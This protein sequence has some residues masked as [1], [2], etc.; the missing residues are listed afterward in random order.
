MKPSKKRIK[1]I[2]QTLKTLY[3]NVKTQLTH[4]NAFELLIATI[5]SAQCTDKQVNAVTPALFERFSTPAALATAPIREIEALIH[6]TGFYHN[7]ARN[8]KKCCRMLMDEFLGEVPS[9]LEALI[10]LPGVGRKTANVVLGAAFNTPAM[11]V[12]THV[13][14]IAS[15]LNLTRHTD[16]V[17]I[18]FDLMEIIPRTE[19]N[20]FSLYLIYFG[21]AYCMA[22][23]PRCPDCPLDAVCAY[24]NKTH[25]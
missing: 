12:D 24:D 25:F 6:S 18:E 23:K 1:N 9:T 3:P 10:R 22:R 11:V 2:L 4:R 8:I 14:R 15:R 20:D 16:P 7:K 13:G 5:L 21:R 17:K 19:W